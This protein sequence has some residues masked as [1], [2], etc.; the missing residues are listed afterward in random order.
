MIASCTDTIRDWE[1]ERWLFGEVVD[2]VEIYDSKT[3]KGFSA[4]KACLVIVK[5]MTCY[6]KFPP[7]IKYNNSDHQTQINVDLTSIRHLS[8]R[9]LIN[10]L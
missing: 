4:F 1:K 2:F 7:Q 10:L 5:I 6:K 8:V 3:A 9:C